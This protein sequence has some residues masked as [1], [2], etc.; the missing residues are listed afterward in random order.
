MRKTK[1]LKSI[2]LAGGGVTGIAWEVGVIAGLVEKGFII[3]KDCQLIGTSAGSAVSAEIANGV[4]IKTLFA[5]QTSD[6]ATDEIYQPY[7]QREV[8]IKNQELFHKVEGDLH[9]ARLRIGRFALKAQTPSLEARRAIIR[10]RLTHESWPDHP[11]LLTAMDVNSAEAFSL[12]DNS[13]LS[14]VDA[15]MAS[16][17]VPGVWPT[18]PF[19][20]KNLM[21][22]GLRSM[23]NADL[24]LGSQHVLILSPLGFSENN[25]VSG[26][27]KAEV[28]R[29]E[30]NKTHVHVI[31]PDSNS[32]P[33]I[34]D[35][36]LD[37]A[38]RKPS[39]MAG[40]EQGKAIAATLN[41]IWFEPHTHQAAQ[42]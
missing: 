10:S 23:T 19:G 9:K 28:E 42:T 18:V 30:K 11:L 6:S 37:P 32:L 17:A 25:P 4:P 5:K 15:V 26:H 8:D 38:M 22:G 12:D 29:L 3:S 34:G 2:V 39:A 14:L 21:D 24:A 35:N 36:V 13:G 1:H 33:A 27:L 16:C 31:T 7:S 41:S 40:L 20:E